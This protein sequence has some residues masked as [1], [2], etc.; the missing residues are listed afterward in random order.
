MY[1]CT[2]SMGAHAWPST[3][4]KRK[5]IRLKWN[6][7]SE[8]SRRNGNR[9]GWRTRPTES[10][11]TNHEKSSMCSTCFPT[12]REQDCTWAIRWATLPAT[13]SPVSNGC[14]ALTCSTPWATMPTDCP[15]S[16]MPYRRGS[17]P[18]RRQ[19][20]ISTA[21]GSSWTKSVSLSTGTER[22]APATLHTTS[23]LSGL[24]ERCLV[25]TIPHF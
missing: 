15:L 10:L 12:R 16:S 24:S 3:Y 21:I 22:C 11:K 23:G 18:R 1:L 5:S 9:S 13:Y 17:I 20:K 19:R 7:T 25:P 6:T 4:P 8:K 2:L 14:K